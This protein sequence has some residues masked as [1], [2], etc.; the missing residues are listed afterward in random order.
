MKR[1]ADRGSS[2]RRG[3]KKAEDEG[4]EEP[5]EQ[6][7]MEPASAPTLDL[8]QHKEEMIEAALLKHGGNVKAAAAELGISERTIYRRQAQKKK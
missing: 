1:T 8:K 3:R 4:A 6:E 7:Q 2:K 5:E